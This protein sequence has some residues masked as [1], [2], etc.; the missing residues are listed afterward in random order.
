MQYPL[1]I[2]VQTVS[3][4]MNVPI[5]NHIFLLIRLCLSCPAIN[6]Q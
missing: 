2:N 3:T 1:D 4:C 6:Q 5:N